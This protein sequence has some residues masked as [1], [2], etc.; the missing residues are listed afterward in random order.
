VDWLAHGDHLLLVPWVIAAA[1]MG[2]HAINQA[3]FSIG[4]RFSGRIVDRHPRLS[5]RLAKV[6][7]WVESYGIRIL[8]VSRSF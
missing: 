7:G 1:F 8:L 4:R 2:T 3:W 6:D 5:R